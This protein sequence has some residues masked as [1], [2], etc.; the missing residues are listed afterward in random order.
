[1]TNLNENEYQLQKSDYLYIL[2]KT[3]SIING[4]FAHWE[5]VPKYNID[6]EFRRFLERAMTFDSR[7]QFDLLMLEFIANLNNG[8]S[9]FD[10]QFLIRKYG[11]NFQFQVAFLEDKW[12]IIDSVNSEISK[13]EII[14]KIDDKNTIDFYLEHK[15]YISASNER[16][17][18][19]KLFNYNFHFPLQFELELSNGNYN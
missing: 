7:Y 3:Y 10:D 15:K 14:E 16:N 2:S 1:M 6:D 19:N 13:G 9:W 18:R 12:T 17:R 11:I 4:Y 5:D 8:H